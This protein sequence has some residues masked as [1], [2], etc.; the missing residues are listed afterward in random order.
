M[1]GPPSL[2]ETLGDL[3]KQSPQIFTQRFAQVGVDLRGADTCMSQQ[4]LDDANIHAL[5]QQVRGGTVPKRVRTEAIIESAL[6]SRLD[7][8]SSCGA[9]RQRREDRL[10]GEQPAYVAMSLP[11]LPQHLQHGI[12]QGKSTL[13]V[14]FANHVQQQLLGVDRRD[15]KPD[16]FSDPQSVG[17][18][19]REA[20]AV[21]GLLQCGDQAATIVVGADVGQPDVAWLADF[22][23]V[24]NGHS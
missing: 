3:V 20:A 8:S 16:R 10:T 5:F 14:A 13:F 7:E 1:A 2:E 24:N 17:V 9:V 11:D 19:E 6:A 15:R 22:F 12:R 21:N 18:N 4:N 23:F